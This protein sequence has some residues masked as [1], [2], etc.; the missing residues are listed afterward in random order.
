MGFPGGTSGKRDFPGGPVTGN[1]PCNSDDSGLISGQETKTSHTTEQVSLHA[2]TTEP[3][4]HKE[5]SYMMQSRSCMPK[6][7]LDTAKYI[8]KSIESSPTFPFRDTMEFYS[9]HH[10]YPISHMLSNRRPRNI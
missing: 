6:L 10:H 9:Q 4:H 2:T 3:M 5:A 1:L 7:R 8:N